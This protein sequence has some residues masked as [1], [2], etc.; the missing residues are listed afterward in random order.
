[1]VKQEHSIE[2]DK[3]LTQHGLTEREKACVFDALQGLTAKESAKQLSISPSTVGEFR[4]RAYEKLGVQNLAELRD[5]VDSW[6]KEKPHEAETNI[7]YISTGLQAALFT[8]K[9]GITLTKIRKARG[10]VLRAFSV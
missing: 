10:I 9:T 2:L 1:M 6:T 3:A 4:L 7:A 5:Q 8:N